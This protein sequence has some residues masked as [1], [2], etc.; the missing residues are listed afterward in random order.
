MILK[1][2]IFEKEFISMRNKELDFLKKHLNET[3]K[4]FSEKE[5]ISISVQIIS[6][7]SG[8]LAEYYRS[9]PRYLID[10]NEKDAFRL[11]KARGDVSL[12]LVG[13]FSDWLNRK[14]RPLKEEDYINAGKFNYWKA[15]YYLDK[16]Y[17]DII[18]AEKEK[19]YFHMLNNSFLF[20][21]LFKDISE[22]FEIYT[23][24]LKR[25]RLE[26]E[27]LSKFFDSFNPARVLIFEK[28]FKDK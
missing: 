6:Y 4:E 20:I 3:L 17:G 25:Y 12:I 11:Y 14:N 19:D 28:L 9:I 18:K 26:S 15:Y 13:F 16:R 21:D 24:L 2:K 27:N 23:D 1:F 10:I 5:K 8:I 22:N 7:I